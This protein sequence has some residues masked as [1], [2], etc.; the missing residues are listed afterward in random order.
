MK[1]IFLTIFLVLHGASALAFSYTLELSETNIQERAD[2]M[3]PL[4]KKK[5][6]V[7]TILT[8]PLIDLIQT[9]NEL[10]LSTDVEIKAPGNIVGNGKV[11]FTGALRYDNDSGSFYF[12]N[13]KVVSLE[14][15]KVPPKTLPK[16]KKILE[17][18]AKKFLAKKAVFT[19]KDDNLKHKLA[20]ST[21]KSIT[22]EDQSLIIELG[23]F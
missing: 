15:N 8:N 5:F 3:M 18:V 12:D 2:A 10:G 11:S 9:T 1:N 13:L 14:V 4:E 16:I 7:T 20:K 23:I 21:L 19:F 22:V 17:L 6:F